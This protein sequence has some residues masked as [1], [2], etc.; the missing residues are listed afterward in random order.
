[1]YNIR[2]LS[3]RK[4]SYNRAA[5]HFLS[6][7]GIA[8][9]RRLENHIGLLWEVYFSR[10]HPKVGTLSRAYCPRHIT[11]T[12]AAVCHG[13]DLISQRQGKVTKVE[14]DNGYLDLRSVGMLHVIIIINPLTA[15]VVG[16]PQMILQ[17]VFSIFPCSPLP[18]GTCRT[19]G[20]SIP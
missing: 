14:N 5:L 19:L 9:K 17:P 6:L 3:P 15:R 7:L 8:S 18:S 1:M 4:V 10:K 20:L 2:S 11:G 12:R 16:A 13:H